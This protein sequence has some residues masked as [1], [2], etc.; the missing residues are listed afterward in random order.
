MDPLRSDKLTK[1]LL[2]NLPNGV[3]LMSNTVVDRYTA[4]FA[5]YVVSPLPEREK[6]WEKIVSLGCNNRLCHIFKN[7]AQAKKWFAESML[8]AT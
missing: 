3:F 8:A 4:V 6:Q 1:K 7:E 2:M 5:E